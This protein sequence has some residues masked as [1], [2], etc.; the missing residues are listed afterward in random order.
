MP[1]T[2]QVRSGDLE[3]PPELTF[4]APRIVIGRGEGCEVRLPDPSVSHRHASIRQRGSDYLL[5]DEGSANGTFVASV[6]LGAHSPRVLKSGDWIRVGRVWLVVQIS[7]LGAPLTNPTATKEL[8]LRLV[9]GALAAQG[10][11]IRLQIEV[12]EGPAKGRKLTIEHFERAYVI[13]RAGA[14]DLALE[15]EGAS[16][17]HAEVIRRGDRLLIRDLETKN[18]TTLADHPV[19]PGKET[20]WAPGV[21]LGIGTSRLRYHDPVIEALGDIER[22]PDEHLALDEDVAPP[23]AAGGASDS[24]HAADEVG[25]PAQALLDVADLPGASRRDRRSIDSKRPPER[26]KRASAPPP[27]AG[28]GKTDVIIALI[29]LGVLIASGLG[30]YWLFASG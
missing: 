6:R 10:D 30:M 8:A 14:V 28:W 7:Q 15:D 24:A 29:A 9:E 3:A 25:P 17:R 1:L 12:L 2:L 21:V 26:P 16:R 22:S 11:E 23:T 20:R 5:V 27:K 19:S 18:G 4:D 13:G